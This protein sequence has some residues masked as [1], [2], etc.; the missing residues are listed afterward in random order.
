MA[1]PEDESWQRPT[2]S[3]VTVIEVKLTHCKRSFSNHHR[4]SLPDKMLYNIGL[5]VAATEVVAIVPAGIILDLPIA[6]AAGTPPTYTTVYSLTD[7]LRLLDVGLAGKIEGWGPSILVFPTFFPASAAASAAALAAQSSDANLLLSSSRRGTIP[8][9]YPL[10]NATI[11]TQQAFGVDDV[12]AANAVDQSL[13]LRKEWDV[14][15]YKGTKSVHLEAV[16]HV[17]TVWNSG[18]KF[19]NKARTVTVIDT[20]V[21]DEKGESIKMEIGKTLIEVDD[22]EIMNK[23]IQFRRYVSSVCADLITM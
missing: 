17:P 23:K 20:G 10:P 1:G 9:I 15:D 13:E 3:D 4:P 18:P 22:D 11:R 14:R 19:V 8:I 5:D 12:C 16:S 6:G 21:L 7:E 2:R